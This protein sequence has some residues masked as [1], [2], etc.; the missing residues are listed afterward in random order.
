MMYIIEINRINYHS[1][2]KI[3]KWDLGMKSPENVS[4]NYYPTVESSAAF[5]E[6]YSSVSQYDHF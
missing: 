1:E 2:K 6:K 5:Q 4:Q 3:E